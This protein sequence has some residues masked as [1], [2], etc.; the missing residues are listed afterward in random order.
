MAGEDGRRAIAIGSPAR[1]G[2]RIPTD[3]SRH[4]WFSRRWHRC[5]RC[6]VW[7]GR[8]QPDFCAIIYGAR[9]I[10]EIPH[11]APPL[12]LAVAADDASFVDRTIELFKAIVR[13]RVQRSCISFSPVPM[14][15]SRKGAVP[16]ISWTESPNGS[17]STNY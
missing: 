16:I 8:D 11:P 4:D 1:L 7:S 6:T 14:G 5:R 17:Q 10:K 12:F 15:L 3:S 13:P 9:E 2:V